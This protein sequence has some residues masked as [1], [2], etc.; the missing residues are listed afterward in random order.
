MASKIA[1]LFLG[2]LARGKRFV[3]PLASTGLQ[4]AAPTLISGA[5][6]AGTTAVVY[7]KTKQYIPYIAIGGAS[8]LMVYAL[9]SS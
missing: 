8:L 2:T 7:S 1:S 6:T 5:V 3:G 4:I 9:A